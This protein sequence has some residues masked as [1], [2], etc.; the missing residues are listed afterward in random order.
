MNHGFEVPFIVSEVED[1]AAD[2]EIEVAVRERKITQVARL[3]VA[4]REPWLKLLRQG[5]DSLDVSRIR[6]D[7]K[8][9]RPATHEVVRVSPGSA[10][11]VQYPH[12][13][14]EAPTE[15][16]VEQIDVDPPELRDQ[17]FL[18]TRGVVQSLGPYRELV[19]KRITPQSLSWSG[20]WYRSGAWNGPQ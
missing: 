15:E 7:S 18:A 4:L 1:R 17:L 11:G 16:L 13:G 19:Q 6:V 5:L 2:D 20:P 10:S 9:I 8:D 14:G 12:F 3:E